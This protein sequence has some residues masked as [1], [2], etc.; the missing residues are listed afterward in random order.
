VSGTLLVPLK[1]LIRV[2]HQLHGIDF[3]VHVLSFLIFQLF[4]H[5]ANIN[6]LFG[7]GQSWQKCPSLLQLKQVAFLTWT[8]SMG[9]PYPLGIGF[10]SETAG[11]MLYLDWV[12]AFDKVT[13]LIEV[14]GGGAQ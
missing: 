4:P 13:V 2:S 8:M 10:F 5:H 6:L 11:V 1:I 7:L 9:V 12:S 3:D 14:G